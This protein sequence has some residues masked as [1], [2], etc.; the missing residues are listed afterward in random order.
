MSNTSF[1]RVTFLGVVLAALAW[2]ATG[3]LQTLLFAERVPRTVAP[4]GEL[5]QFER[6][7][8]DVFDAAAPS[9]VYIFTETARRSMFGRTAVS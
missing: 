3:L 8:T 5:A 4:R 6:T 9:V 2:F 1:I 7:A